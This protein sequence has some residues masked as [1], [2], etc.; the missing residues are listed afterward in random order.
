[1]KTKISKDQVY[2]DSNGH[3]VVVV[4]ISEN[5]V[6]LRDADSELVVADIDS[7][8]QDLASGE[9]IDPVDDPA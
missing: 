4:K 8:I 2:L 6:V 7:V 3:A 1:M 5:S 9:L